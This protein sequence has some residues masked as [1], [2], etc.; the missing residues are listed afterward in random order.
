M[1]EQK[2][3]RAIV[4]RT[5][6]WK[7]SSKIVTLYSEEDG[8]IKMIARGAFRK[9]NPFAGKLETL[10]LLR[11]DYVSKKS[12]SLQILVESE[13]IKSFQDLRLDLKRVPYALSMLEL[14]QQTFE[15]G[16]PDPVFFNFLLEMVQATSVTRYPANALIYFLLKLASY[17]GFKPQLRLCRGGQDAQCS[18]S[19][20]LSLNNGSVSCRNCLE[21]VSNGIRFT[22]DEYL[23]LKNLQ[24]LNYRRVSNWGRSH[25]NSAEIISRLVRFI[26]YHFDSNLKLESLS[27]LS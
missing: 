5:I 2:K 25:K 4:V 6:R 7:E 14:I 13:L 27:F 11:V 20:Y 16:E 12:R 15:D 24:S 8:L 3:S 26:N 22:R 18:D 23:Y 19:V 10:S 1:S 21:R 17:L 9:N